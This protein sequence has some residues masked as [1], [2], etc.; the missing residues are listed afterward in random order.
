MAKSPSSRAPKPTKSPKPTKP[1]KPKSKPTPPPG[2]RARN[3]AAIRGRIVSAALHLFQTKGFEATT[4]RAIAGKAGVG[5]GTVFNYFKTK[6][7]IALYFFEQEVDHAIAAVRENPRLKNAPLEERLFALV[8]AQLEYLAPYEKF[9][10]AAFVEALKPRSPLGP[11][12]HRANELRH[13]YLGFVQE[14]FEESSGRKGP[15]STLAWIGPHAF[16]V[17]YL[18]ALLFWL[19]DESPRKEHTLAFLDRSLSVGVSV[20]QGKW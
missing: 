15:P 11:F 17:F 20:F 8:Q 10:G 4:T 1:Q 14:L 6:E 5:E 7:E 3:K 12:G 9:I 13:R 19:Q 16:W 18:G 2:T